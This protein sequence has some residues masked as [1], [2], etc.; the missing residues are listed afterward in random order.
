MLLAFAARRYLGGGHTA[1]RSLLRSFTAGEGIA[2]V[3]VLIAASLLV[4]EAPPRTTATASSS[5]LGPSPLAGRTL[6]LA[7]IAGQLLVAVTANRSELQFVVTPPAETQ[8][9][10]S[11]GLTADARPPGA[12]PL[13]LF[14]RPCGSGCFT[15]RYTLRTG[16]TRVTAHVSSKLWRG[17]DATFDLPAP[18]GAARPKLLQRVI[19]AMH[20]VRKLVVTERVSSGPNYNASPA[21]YT[22]SGR[23]FLA[24]EVFGSGAVDVR[25]L[26]KRAGLTE[27]AF[28][29]PGSNIWYRLWIDRSDRIRRELI[30][31]PGHRISRTFTY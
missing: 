8:E 18:I 13:D 12:P 20:H 3:G 19:D 2:L 16:M 11:V 6:R 14:P 5:L 22:M 27:V 10:G 28:A 23:A 31:D 15:I 24:T 17:G 30:A 4:N 1:K 7:D 25:A 21:A 29:S 26:Q 9:L